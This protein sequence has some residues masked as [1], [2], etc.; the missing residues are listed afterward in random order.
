MTHHT[1]LINGVKYLHLCNPNHFKEKSLEDNVYFT[2]R[3]IF[4]NIE[5]FNDAMT[6]SFTNGK[7]TNNIPYE[8][9]D[10]YFEY[11]DYLTHKKNLID[12]TNW[13]ER[14]TIHD[15]NFQTFDEYTKENKINLLD[16]HELFL[17]EYDNYYNISMTDYIQFDKWMDQFNELKIKLKTR[18]DEV[19]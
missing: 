2:L 14:I 6:A 19:S 11:T 16:T 3:D 18:L 5:C 12:L 13:I 10:D 7:L 4:V 8:E 17:E 9:R 1:R 15:F